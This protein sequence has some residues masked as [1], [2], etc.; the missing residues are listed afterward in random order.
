M[1]VGDLE[2]KRVVEPAPTVTCCNTTSIS[3]GHNTSTGLWQDSNSKGQHDTSC[4][5]TQ[6]AEGCQSIKVSLN[7]SKLRSASPVSGCLSSNCK[8][9]FKHL[10]TQWHIFLAYWRGVRRD[11]S[12]IQRRRQRMQ[13]R[14]RRREGRGAW[15]V[16]SVCNE[17]TVCARDMQPILNIWCNHTIIFFFS[18][19]SP[20]PDSRSQKHVRN[21]SPDP[22]PTQVQ[23][24]FADYNGLQWTTMKINYNG[25]QWTTTTMTA[26]VVTMDYNY[27]GLQ[28]QC[29]TN[30]N[31]LQITMATMAVTMDYKLQ[32]LQITMDYNGLQYQRQWL[33]T[34]K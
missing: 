8:A 1:T 13:L 16:F 27:N 3:R 19:Q 29:T 2:D 18:N 9:S 26:M 22:T 12:W 31:G 21:L 25:L 30:Y 32:W 14:W 17:G 4:V 5:L 33:T 20:S 11:W 24:L 10:P 28:W 7:I 15:G 34:I 6:W 23:V